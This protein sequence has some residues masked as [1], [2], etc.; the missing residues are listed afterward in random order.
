M[1]HLISIIALTIGLATST[2]SCGDLSTY[3]GMKV[4]ALHNPGQSL[5]IFDQD[6]TEQDIYDNRFVPVVSLNDTIIR[7]IERSEFRKWE[8]KKSARR[9]SMATWFGIV[10]AWYALHGNN[11][12]QSIAGTACFL[13]AP[14]LYL[15]FEI[16]NPHDTTCT[17]GKPEER[18][19]GQLARII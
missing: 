4:S 5:V 19:S 14:L 18:F 8:Y 13:A 7:Y 11:L 16:P 9:L 3:K 17:Y 6:L 2:L 10:S 12:G 15:F 1:N